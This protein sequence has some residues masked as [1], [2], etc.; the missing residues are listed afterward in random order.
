MVRPGRRS[1]RR[2]MT[3]TVYGL[4]DED[5]LVATVRAEDEGEAESLFTANQLVGSSVRPITT[6]GRRPDDANGS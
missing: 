1:Y 5:K 2:L 6:H 4:Y 3:L